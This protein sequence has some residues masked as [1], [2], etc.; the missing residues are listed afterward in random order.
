MH[1]H[2][3]GT[4]QNDTKR[5]RRTHDTDSMHPSLL[6]QSLQLLLLVEVSAIRFPLVQLRKDLH[7]AIQADTFH[8]LLHTLSMQGSRTLDSYRH[9]WSSVKCMWSTFNLTA[10]IS[11]NKAITLCMGIKCRE[12]SSRSPRHLC[13]G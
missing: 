4:T 3:Y 13:V 8:Q 5:E 6:Y 10:V 1:T 9:P 7:V 12:T 11:G 2:Y